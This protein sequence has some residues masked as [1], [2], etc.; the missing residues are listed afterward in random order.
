[1]TIPSLP[2]ISGVQFAPVDGFPTYAVSDDGRVW[3]CKIARGRGV[4]GNAWREMQYARLPKGYRMV[5]LHHEGKRLRQS[6]HRLVLHTFHPCPGPSY[7]AAHYPDPSVDNCRLSNLVWA[8]QRENTAHCLAQGRMARGERHSQAKLTT[9]SVLEIYR[10]RRGG[11]SYADIAKELHIHPGHV[12]EIARGLR[13]KHLYHYA[14][15][16]V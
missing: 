15:L 5:S 8:T 10:M 1:M 12:S 4:I 6:V 13:W 16:E 11:A 14:D 7:Q 9:I 3:T 2:V